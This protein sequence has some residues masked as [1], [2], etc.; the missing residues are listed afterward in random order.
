M[1]PQ[2][3]LGLWPE[4]HNWPTRCRFNHHADHWTHLEPGPPECWLLRRLNDA[5][6]IDKL[7]GGNMGRVMT[8]L[9]AFGIL[10][11]LYITYQYGVF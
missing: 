9:A 4:Q 3:Q 2:P 6:A 7:Q 5:V 1:A 8:I 10:A 11:A